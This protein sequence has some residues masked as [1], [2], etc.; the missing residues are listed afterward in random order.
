M[1][2]KGK[3]LCGWQYYN[4]SLMPV[5]PPYEKAD[6][7]P[8]ES[9]AAWKYTGGGYPL[10]ARWTEDFDCGKETEW[11]YCIKDTPFAIEALKA[12]H[13][14]EVKRGRK[15]FTVRQI[16]PPEYGEELA[17]IEEQ[18][19]L[20]YPPEYRPH[21]RK[22]EFLEKVRSWEAEDTVVLTAFDRESGECCGYAMLQNRERFCGFR[23]LKV[24]PEYEKKGINA[25]LVDKILELYQEPLKQ[26]YLIIDGERNV[27][28]QTSFQDYLEKY[29]GFRKAYCTLHVAYRPWVGA[30]VKLL[31]P[32]RQVLKKS[33]RRSLH[34]VKG[35]LYQEEIRRT[36]R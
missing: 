7:S 21:F 28:H 10:L 36:F 18:A 14:Y 26:G 19:F 5:T 31:Y 29:F 11:W 13:R 17:R 1:K 24:L 23:K 15:H 32:F 3:E 34:K 16:N 12:K 4:H 33:K 9:G 2:N 25:A 30:A 35:I 20:A 8:I 6:T 27:L 22:N